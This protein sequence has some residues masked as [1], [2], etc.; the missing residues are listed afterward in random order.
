[1]QEKITEELLSVLKQTSSDE[2]GQVL[3]KEKQNLFCGAVWLWLTVRR[4]AYQSA[5]LYF[6]HLLCGTVLAGTN[7]THSAAVRHEHAVCPHSARCGVSCC[8]ESE[9]M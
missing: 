3:C 1:M 6:A 7:T 2:I 8:A 5:R 4:K 9:N